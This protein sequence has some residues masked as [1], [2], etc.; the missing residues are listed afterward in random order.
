MLDISQSKQ[1][2]FKHFQY[3]VNFS[4]INRKSTTFYFLITVSLVFQA[5]K[6]KKV[7]HK[8]LS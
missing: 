1:M 7:H 6:E 8:Q 3:Q 2:N 4:S 5:R